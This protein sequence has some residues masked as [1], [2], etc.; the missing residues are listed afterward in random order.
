MFMNLQSMSI[1]QLQEWN[2]QGLIPGPDESEQEFK[3]RVEYA[4]KLKEK[5]SEIIENE[6]ISNEFDFAKAEEYYGIHP[7]WV[8]IFYSNEKLAPWHGGCAWIFQEKEGD[9]T[10]ACLQLRK[11][12]FGKETRKET[13]WGIY[14]RSEVVSHEVCHIGRMM[15]EEPK[16][17]EI[18]AYQTSSSP[19][20]RWFGPIIQSAKEAYLFGIS[21][22]LILLIDLFALFS[23]PRLV[24]SEILWLKAIPIGLIFFA[25]F[26]LWRRQLIFRRCLRQIEKAIPNPKKVS[27]VIFR[28]TD[29]E[30]VDFSQMPPDLIIKVANQE[31]EKSLRWKLIYETYFN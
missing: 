13:L 10:S 23:D 27:G 25:L 31:K 12:F 14:P 28:L 20:R 21:L 19:F 4:Y 2:S 11:S 15:F 9:P 3:K 22:I 17:E 16:F 26:R 30:I 7:S 29:R 8:P 1:K 5:I 18:I 6:T 24:Y